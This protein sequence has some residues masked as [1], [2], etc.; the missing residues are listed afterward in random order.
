MSYLNLHQFQ[1]YLKLTSDASSARLH[2]QLQAGRCRFDSADENAKAVSLDIE[3]EQHERVAA[4]IEK[5]R[6]TADQLA[7]LGGK[8]HIHGLIRHHDIPEISA[9]KQDFT[10][11][12]GS[13]DVTGKRPAAF[14][15]S[16]AGKVTFRRGIWEEWPSVLPALNKWEPDTPILMSPFCATLLHEAIGHPLEEDYWHV[17][18]FKY[19]IGESICSAPLTLLDKPDMED[20]A[21][22]MSHDDCGAPATTTTLVQQG[23]LVSNMCA[24]NGL[25]RRAGFRDIARPRAGNFLIRTGG[26]DP[27][28]WLKEHRELLYVTWIQSG[29]WWPGTQRLKVLTGPVYLLRNGE[30]VAHAPWL[31]LVFSST[32]LVKRII[33]IGDDLTRDPVVHWCV[34]GH[35]R[36][37]MTVAAPSLLIRGKQ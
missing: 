2:R 6:A 32:D 24:P 35:Q 28:D 14:G 20:G 36:V 17:S 27:A 22:T 1:A 8:I 34:K 10:G 13:V 7:D 37:P 26:H 31:R 15:A 29:N 3:A 11:L 25:R 4:L 12:W 16:M 33:A 9:Y 21:G 30:P 19:S 18:P 5:M 23:I